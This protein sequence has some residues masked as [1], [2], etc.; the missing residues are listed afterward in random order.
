M[1][2]LNF[3]DLILFESDDFLIIN[4][5]PFVSTLEDRN[6]SQNILALAKGYD[7]EAQVCQNTCGPIS[8]EGA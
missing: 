5:P 6:T 1:K 7:E 4:K 2:K 8:G 3:E